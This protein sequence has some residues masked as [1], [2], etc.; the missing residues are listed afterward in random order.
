MRLSLPT[1]A[2]VAL[3]SL[4]FSTALPLSARAA[5]PSGLA[6]EY[7]DTHSRYLYTSTTRFECP[8]N[9]LAIAGAVFPVNV[10]LVELAGNQT[11]RHGAEGDAVVAQIATGWTENTLLWDVGQLELAEGVETI[12]GNTVAVKVTDCAPA[13]KRASGVG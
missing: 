3:S 8:L 10:S 7:L 11:Y 9:G 6:V 12:I 2:L 4:P 13:G 5:I 1:L